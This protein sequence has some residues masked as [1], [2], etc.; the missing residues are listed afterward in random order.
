MCGIN[1]HNDEYTYNYLQ[2]IANFPPK[3][4]RNSS[5]NRSTFGLL[6]FKPFTVEHK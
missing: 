4:M 5:L 2:K 1:L 3:F 6:V